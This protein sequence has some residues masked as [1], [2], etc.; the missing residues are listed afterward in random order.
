MFGRTITMDRIATAFTAALVAIALEFGAS[1]TLG[2]SYDPR[3]GYGLD[4]GEGDLNPSADDWIASHGNV[5]MKEQD[6]DSILAD[7]VTQDNSNSWRIFDYEGNSHCYCRT[8]QDC[9]PE[10]VNGSRGFYNGNLLRDPSGLPAAVRP[11]QH[12]H[13]SLQA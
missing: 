1:V 7:L 2:S 13:P 12:E 11:V 4:Y 9:L 3:I 8:A 5:Q 6:A 10:R